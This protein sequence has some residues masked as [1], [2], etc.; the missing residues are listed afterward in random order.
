MTDEPA[1]FCVNVDTAAS[2]A[3]APSVND[4]LETVKLPLGLMVPLLNANVDVRVKLV[5][6]IVPMLLNVP[7]SYVTAP[8]QVKLNVAK[9]MVPAV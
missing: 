5:H 2:V 4:P 7:P 3:D 1:P 6:V 8:E 9:S